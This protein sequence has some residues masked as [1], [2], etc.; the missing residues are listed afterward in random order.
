M[1]VRRALV[2]LASG[3]LALLVLTIPLPATTPSPGA[4]EVV[5]RARQYAYEPGVVRVSRGDRVTLV[6]EADDMT[7]GLYVDGYGAE[8][9]GVPGQPA[10]V[11][12]VADR[13]GKFRLRCSKICGPLHPFMLGDLIVEPEQQFW[14]GAAL[15]ILAAAGTVL[16]LTTGTREERA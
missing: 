14:R 5:V 1:T 12:F 15:A 9:V 16:F 8:A 6:L 13:P 11:T 2:A 10:R 7:H 4:R 3:V